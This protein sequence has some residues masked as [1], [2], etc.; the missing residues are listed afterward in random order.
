M[1][2]F[3]IY[4]DLDGQYVVVSGAGETAVAKLRLLLKT[5]ARIAVFGTDPAGRIVRWAAQGRL[6]LHT[7]A[8]EAADLLGAR[9]LYASNDEAAGDARA[10]ALG[11]AAG[12]LVNIVDNLRDSDFITPAIVDRDPVTVAIGTEGAAPVLARRI[13]ADIEERLRPETGILAR[14]ARQFRTAAKALPPG[15]PRRQFWSRY[16]DEV[17]PQAL[18]DGGEDGVRSALGRLLREDL[19]AAAIPGRVSIVGAGPGDPELLTLK[20]RRALHEAD[21]VI[22]DRQVAAGVLEL[23]RREATV[24]EVGDAPGWPGRI[25]DDINA[26]VVEHA[27][28]GA[29]VVRLNSGD[30][31][32]HGRIDDEIAGL[33]AA[34]IA[35]EIVPGV[36]AAAASAAEIKVSLVGLRRI[37]GLRIPTGHNVNGLAEQDRSGRTAPGATAATC[38]GAL[39][40]GAPELKEAL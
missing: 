27:A 34:G 36:S 31:T 22:H 8:I 23:A 30:P 28:K 25:K 17:G 5:T 33:D 20:A 37:S 6:V 35:F 38:L 1:Q 13:K 12:A 40:Q 7:R 18:R 14:I 11:R 19:D 32:V 15:R 24:H 2:H 9:L 39:V 29:H 26:L 10:A 4:L 16:Y 3:P 21:V